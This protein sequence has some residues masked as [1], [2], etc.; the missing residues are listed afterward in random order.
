MESPLSA[1]VGQTLQ[2]L[3]GGRRVETYRAL[4]GQIFRGTRVAVVGVSPGFVDTPH[5]RSMIVAGDGDEAVG[6]IARR[7]GA[8]VVSDNFAEPF[9]LGPGDEITVPAPAGPM[10]MRI[11]AVVTNDFSGDRGSIIMHRDRLAAGWGGDTQVSHFNVF[12]APGANL[13]A[14]RA[15]IVQAL[16]STYV[17][18]VLTLPQLV[19]YHQNMIDRAFAFTYAIQL[20]VIAVTLA[21]IVDLLT[22]QIIER[23]REMGL[24]R[25]IGADEPVIARAIWLEA[26][27]I[28]LSGAVLGAV[29][30]RRHLAALGP[31]ELPDP[32]RL[33]RRAPLRRAHRGVVRAARRRRG[34]HRRPTRGTPRAARAGPERA[35]LR[36]GPLAA[37]SRSVRRDAS[38]ARRMRDLGPGTLRDVGAGARYASRST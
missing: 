34:D 18:K 37:C 8:V 14:T 22:T 23:R 19:A 28:G 24:L 29:G 7:T 3:P 20:L 1:D 17:V 15:A 27:V 38:R 21:G 10:P 11:S 36:V 35:A 5:F 33:R 13:E 25:V 32:D 26:L 4:Q 31:R 9:G 16:R 6:A 12:L 30:Q 2:G